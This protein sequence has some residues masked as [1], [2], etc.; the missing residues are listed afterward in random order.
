MSLC[1]LMAYSMRYQCLVRGCIQD[2]LFRFGRLKTVLVIKR[3]CSAHFR[4]SRRPLMVPTPSVPITSFQS[5][6]EIEVTKMDKL[7]CTGRCEK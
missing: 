7:V 1:L 5:A 6:G 4:R 3:S 2:A